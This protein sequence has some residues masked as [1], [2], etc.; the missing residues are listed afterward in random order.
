MSNVIDQRVVEMRFDN[1]QF[2]SGVSTSMTTL[3]KLKRALKFDGASKGLENIS[4]S[5]KKVDM[6]ALASGIETVRSKFSALEVMGVTALANITNSAVNAGKRMISALTI[7][8]VMTGFQ[9]YETQINAI[10]TV[11]A[12][13][14]GA[15]TTL[16]QVNAALDQLNTYAD[17]TIY[18]FTEMTRNI[19]TFTAAGVDL[20]TSVSAIKGIA[21]LAAV[22][23]SSSQQASTAMYQLS[24]AIA[25]G[26]V[27]LQDWN[28]VVNAGMGGKVF[29]D[30]LMNTAEAMGIVVDRSISFRESISQ[31]GGKKSWLTSDVLLNTLK[32]F[33]GDLT[34]A[35]LAAMG[36]NQTQIESIQQMAVTANDAATKVKTVSQLW[37]TM[38]ESVQS[39]WTQ[40][41]EILVGDFEEAK[42]FLTELSDI[43]GG[44][45][46]Q[47]AESRNNLLYDSMT[48]NWKKI[49]DGITE[50][51]LSATDFQNKV[52]EIGKSKGLNIDEI[53]A[54]YGSLESAFKNGALSSD[55][56]NEALI[57]M[58]GSSEEIQKKLANLRGEYKSNND[59]LK[60][61]NKAG[62]DQSDIQDLIIKNTNGETIALNDLT[63]AQLKSIGYTDDQI[64]SIRTLSQYA[65]LAGG[66]L[67]TFIDNVSVPQ[68]REMLIDA[69]RVSLRSLI[70]VF[71]AVGQAWKNVFPPT[72]SEQLL[73]VIES[74]RDLALNLR[75]SEE[76]LDKI[77]RTF[78]G[79]FS[80]LRI[81]QQAIFAVGKGIG[82]LLGNFSGLGGGILT[83][84]A[85]IGDW[86]YN[87]DQVIEETDIFN[88]VVQG[89]VGF[90]E[91][92][93]SSIKNF[94]SAVKEWVQNLDLPILETFHGFLER[95]HE[96]MSQVGEAADTMGSG[97]IDAIEAMGNAIANSSFMQILQGL[98]DLIRTLGTGIANI[99]RELGSNLAG[100]VGSINFDRV[101][102]IFNTAA[103]GGVALG[104]RGFLNTL[105]EPFEGLQGILE[106]VTGILDGV[107]GSLEAWQTSLK[108]DTL[109]KIAAA[110]GVLAASILIISTIDS[111]KLTASLGAVTVL[112]A[113]LM[114]S[115]AI[116][117][118][119]SGS[120]VGVT[121]TC[122]AMI[123]VST[124]ILI[125][126][127]ALKKVSELD[128]ESMVTGLVG[129]VGLS[130]TMV[131]A[132][133]SLGSGSATVIKGATQMIIF[134]AAIKVL[135]S[136][137]EDLGALSWNELAKGLSGVGILFAEISI[138]L[139][140]AKFS[141]Q[142]IT[143]A[144]GITILA[145]AMKILASACADFGAMNWNEI[146]KGLTSIGVLLGE[147]AIFAN[148]TANAKNL[149]STG[150][151][152]VAIA[153]SMKVFASAVADFGDMSW[154]ELARGLTGMAGALASVTVAVNLMPKNMIGIGTGLIAVSGALAIVAEVLGKLGGMSWDEIAKGLTA[155]GGSLGILAIGLNAMN[156]TLAGS[157]AMV[158][159]ATSLA[160]LT[161]VL[162][163]LG[164]M[165]WEG[166]AKGLVAVAGAFT[167]IGVAG[168]VLTPLVPTILGLGGAFTLIGVGIAGIGVGLLAAGAGLTALAAGFTA[169]AAGGI[170]GATAVVSSLTII[171]T[172]VA[173]LIPEVISQIGRGIIELCKVIAE[174]APAIG[175][176]VKAI[177]LTIVDVLIECVPEIAD[178]ALKLITEVLA[179]LVQYTPQIVDAI[180][181]FV[182]LLLEGVAERLPELI[183]AVT[184]VLVSLFTGVLDA[185][186][187]ID[188][189]TLVKMVAGIGLLAGVMAAL[190]AIS[191]L[192][193]GAMVGVLGL[194]A[195]VAEI[196][197][198]L[199]AFGALAQIP[200]LDWLIGE[201][202]KLLQ[203]IGTAI[204]G[205]IGGIIGGVMGGITNQFP[206]MG[207]DLAAFMTNVQPFIDGA[208]S[209]DSSVL[210]GV[211]TLAKTVLALTAANVLDG[212]TSWLTGGSSL[213]RFA[214]ELVLF[215]QAMKD[216]SMAIAGMDGNLIVNAATAGKTLTEMAS[217]IPNSGGVLGFFAGENDM[218]AFGEQ[219]IPF[220]QAMK[221]FS[222]V[223][224]G[225]D[226]NAVVNAAT[227]G[228]A[229]AEMSTTIPN[230]G[231]VVGFF[232]GEN[233]MD[234]FGEQLIPFG[235]AMK[236]YSIAVSGLDVNAVVN[237]ATAGK[238]L[239][240]LASTIPNSGGAVS[241]F[242]GD[243][244]MD[245]FGVQLVTFGLAMKEYSIAVSG[246]DSDAIVNSTTAGKALV[247]LANT[248]PNCGGLI[249]FFTGDN[250]MADFGDQL[251]SFGQDFE[252]YSNYM[253]SVD[254]GVVTSTTNAAKALVSLMDALPE[255][256]LFTNETWLD[257][258]GQQVSEFGRYFSIYYGYVSSVNTSKLSSVISEVNNL[259]EMAKGMS[260]FDTSG[261]SSF[262]KALT[263]LG[264]DGIDGFIKAFANANPKVKTAAS[265]M[266][267]AFITTINSK[268]TEIDK[269]FSTLITNIT[270]DLS[271]KKDEFKKIAGEF[272][273]Q[274]LTGLNEK[275]VTVR[276]N[277][278]S[279][280]TN[281]V[282]TM[283][284][285]YSSFRE[286]GKHLISGFI[287]GINDNRSAANR[288]AKS[289]ANSV[290]TTMKQTLEIHSPSRVMRDEVGKYVVEGLA[291]GITK[292]MS[293]E[294]AAEQKAQNITNAFQDAFDELDVA[295]QTQELQETLNNEAEDY[296]ARYERQAERVELALAKYE[297]LLEVLGETAIETQKA[298]NEY[299]QEEIDLREME[300]QKTKEAYETAIALIEERKQASEMSLV[301][302]LAAY[303]RLQSAYAEGTAERIELDSKIE[304]V[305]DEIAAA[306]KDYY[307]RLSEIEE[308][309]N[310]QRTQID[311]QYEDQRTSV[312]ENANQQRLQLQQEYAD[313]VQQI[314]DQLNADIEAAEQA[315]EDSV[316][317]RADT[318]YSA[319]GLFDAANKDAKIVDGETLMVNLKNQLESL[320]DWTE[321]LNFLSGK[322]LDEEFIEELREMGPDAAAEIKALS[323]MTDS[324]LD[325]YVS[326]WKQKHELANDQALYEL[327][328]LREETNE[329][330]EQMKVDA[331]NELE[332]YRQTWN[333][334][335][336]QLNRDTSE[337][338][339][340]L[341][342]DWYESISDLNEQTNEQIEELE[343]D[344]LESVANLK[345]ETEN[346]FTEMTEELINLLGKKTKWTEAGANIIEGVLKGV[347]SN[348][349][350]LVSGLESV[351]EE[352]LNAAKEKL[353]INS[354]S[355]EFAKLGRYSDE[356][357]A[358]GLIR[359]QSVITS[360]VESLGTKTLDSLRNAV[361]KIS[362]M[363]NSDIDAQPTIRPVLDLSEIETGVTQLDTLFNQQQA[364]QLNSS[365]GHK[366]TIE[367][368]QNGVESSTSGNSYQFVQNNY[369]PKSLSR[370]EI[371]RQTKNQ[372]STFER[373]VKA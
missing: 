271:K 267:N 202:G 244:D 262:G 196:G 332:E 235:R 250:D 67:K 143:T 320:S 15:G 44:I 286:V 275:Q 162:S 290:L 277:V 137:C 170:A 68:G 345:E 151:A 26:T 157:A 292:D 221:D 215:G 346:E 363:V 120:I 204:G 81:G 296:T 186:K 146:A 106:G 236:E 6:S 2:E 209:I 276:S 51:G 136:A 238:A 90:I 212:V 84:T 319:F 361:S 187:S 247:E 33:T 208:K 29:Q 59:I 255:D 134:A 348:S 110:I 172:G 368:N 354:P 131:V 219:L 232:T 63:D 338:L 80:V 297:N 336:W 145:A 180:F 147:I 47:S 270:T 349:G 256:K 54:D 316:K 66:S 149:L 97:V 179:A 245:R 372:F 300:E 257:E 283:K 246:L 178:G 185:V 337:Q 39:G 130:A 298:Y 139:N 126:A 42:S 4:S 95:I 190:S 138:F 1:K 21:N 41:W 206:K 156:G 121:K 293:V 102:D 132:A 210:D 159:A 123:L 12:N 16:E 182:I 312:I 118:R 294:E 340:E 203:S 299:L 306:T 269:T 34:N 307:D 129:I 205:F 333:E 281:I 19:G 261:M 8:P 52:I 173:A 101:F 226:S 103:L 177:V 230:S 14:S 27:G 140:T 355:K 360:S 116:F 302:E 274:F 268:K 169:I 309:A 165:S 133:K 285:Q 220:G 342:N 60:A 201:G 191:S 254:A 108:A 128:F 160:V 335:M 189:T 96:R 78:Q 119:L 195:V 351:M 295:D 234:R 364:L 229:L 184:D 46:S 109:L 318:I 114:G 370:V 264:N 231:G 163:V 334:Q 94:G 259:V 168:A 322:G 117:S 325:E 7:D 317:S 251:V 49:S 64:D 62:Y 77:Q 175:E 188:T 93:A 17:K 113:D 310:E 213:T 328:S 86:L 35:E 371:Y 301:E 107:K 55:L 311:Q 135:A 222:I 279:F 158:V 122:A 10:Q 125:L 5:A 303:K 341:R 366:A 25:A 362:E 350:R 183:Q 344:W 50:A 263:K 76:T 65:D 92:V 98:W 197:L 200:G 357:F 321:D 48:S 104:I 327:Q 223:V 45:I 79:L 237:S 260:N 241:F 155:L 141:G 194:A 112:F 28:S 30:A 174:G 124:S 127:S 284:S 314:N 358:Q 359:Y 252:Q 144:T 207:S 240:E 74:I 272:I 75:P 36:F 217:T 164:A 242:T 266:I 313:K 73:S 198:I 91:N 153:A 56:L 142:S 166:I 352:A 181:D 323:E 24:Q 315:C 22:S 38:K 214:E 249:S 224:A 105:S 148:V 331:E 282:T 353:G 199:A 329:T 308:S 88:T 72:T 150:T 167:V 43:F 3:D 85:N 326:L 40:T 53:V 253:K 61:L 347:V 227:A 11:L 367:D 20:D 243:N 258:F 89:L 71:G 100:A 304:S 152:L 13:T 57:K 278:T 37:D 111:K 330:I 82:S 87:L 32:Q 99:F 365:I 225:M 228:K 171:I 211:T 83:V 192:V 23:G 233:D 288:A 18:N 324:E 115:M 373:M 280:V 339:W 265:E 218:S 70:D 9:E 289:L 273:T 31:A 248:I 287:S 193:P 343:S 291:E 356:G 154:E 161:P 216:F 305:Q 58:T 369:S 176:A 69:M 239:V